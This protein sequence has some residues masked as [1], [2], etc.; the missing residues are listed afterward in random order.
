MGLFKKAGGAMG[1]VD[2]KLLKNGL[3]A[4]G[5]VLRCN[6]AAISVGSSDGLH[7]GTEQVC[8]VTVNVTGL[9]GRPPY[10]VTCTH[11]IPFASLP[12]MRAPGATVAVRVD[13]NDP[14]HIALDLAEQTIR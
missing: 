14:Q 9:V 2:K 1:H 12:Q 5:E 7:P 11:P 4:R 6:T 13:P 8:D 3:P 10:Q